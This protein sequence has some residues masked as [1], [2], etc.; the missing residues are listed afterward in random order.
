MG[1]VQSKNANVKLFAICLLIVAQY[2]YEDDMYCVSLAQCPSFAQFSLYWQV[3][4]V[5]VGLFHPP[6]TAPL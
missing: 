1:S 5:C 3:L 6:V 4:L 2:M